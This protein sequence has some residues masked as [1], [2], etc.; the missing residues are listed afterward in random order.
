MQFPAGVWEHA[1]DGSSRVRRRS[2]A[3]TAKG[4]TTGAGRSSAR[5]A[6]TK[7]R[8]TADAGTQRHQTGAKH[9]G[10]AVS[11]TGSSYRGA[12]ASRGPHLAGNREDA[13]STTA[14]ARLLESIKLAA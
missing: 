3:D 10:I 12:A 5:P 11:A 2:A 8:A 14:A 6:A 7:P 1:S 13:A 4:A 9:A